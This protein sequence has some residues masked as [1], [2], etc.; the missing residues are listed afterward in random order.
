MNIGA[1]RREPGAGRTTRRAPGDGVGEWAPGHPVAR[2]FSAHR[3]GIHDGFVAA[4]V[5]PHNREAV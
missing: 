4:S 3:R 5:A 2:T 1:M